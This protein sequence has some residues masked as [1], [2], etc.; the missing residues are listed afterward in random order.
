MKKNN[1][2]YNENINNLNINSS[3]NNSNNLQISQIKK[4]I[5]LLINSNDQ[6]NLDSIKFKDLFAT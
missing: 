1:N 4:F 5:E 2:N 6:I 3:S